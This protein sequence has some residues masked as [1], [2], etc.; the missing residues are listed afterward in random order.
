[1][2]TGKKA[3][4]LI[5]AVFLLLTSAY[6]NS[7]ALVYVIHGIAGQ[8]LDLSPD[9]PVDVAVDDGCILEGFAYGQVAGP[10]ELPT[11]TYDIDISLAD[12]DN[13]CS[14][15]PVIEAEVPFDAGEIAIVIAHLAED[16]TPTAS[17]FVISSCC[18]KQ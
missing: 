8:D 18:G 3:T 5:L 2:K 17:K 12:N 13:P 11:G 10:L 7:N 6:G 1:M 14:N 15:L 9:L 16:G 4:G